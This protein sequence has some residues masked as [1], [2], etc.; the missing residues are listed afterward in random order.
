M[1]LDMDEVVTPDGEMGIIISYV[2]KSHVSASQLTVGGSITAVSLSMRLNLSGQP[3][4]S[5]YYP[6]RNVLPLL[7]QSTLWSV[8]QSAPLGTAGSERRCFQSG[9][10]ANEHMSLL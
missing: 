3:L 2:N 9:I 6:F 4:H 5:A 1:P 8:I 10:H 7:L